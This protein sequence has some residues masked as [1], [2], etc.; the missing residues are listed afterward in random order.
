MV[1]KIYDLII[2]GAGPAGITA[3]IYAARHQLKFTIISMD[4]GGQ[5]A[6]STD[7]ENYTG[8]HFLSGMDLIK[9]FQKH[10][11]DYKIELKLRE[12][13]DC[14]RKKGG[15][16]EIKT[17]K[18][19]YSAKAVIIASGKQPK[20]LNVQ[21][22]DRLYNKGVSYC[23]TCDAPLFRDKDVAVVGGG[24][25]A[26]QAALLLSKYAK[27]VY[28]L[29]INA[30]LIG[31]EVIVK[32]VFKNKKI[33]VITNAKTTGIF[34]ENGVSALKFIQN[35]NESTINLQGVFIEVGLIIECDFAPLVDKNKWK[36]IKIK[37]S[38][39]STEENMTNIPGIFAAGDCTD[40][41]AKQII[42]AAGEG[43]KA[44]LAAIDYIE[45]NSETS[46]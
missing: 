18:S 40:I 32:K 30:K 46:E 17:N 38:T 12:R 24:N 3:A 35:G 33:K 5:T 13:V 27:T 7:V 8:Y 26:L 39:K 31:E 15:I 20:K 29:T 23:A 36:E 2:V 41:P 44:A 28:L 42:V 11:E 43:A 6:M 22:E 34:G 45:K 4:I 37:R 14:I 25:S 19:R 16:F 9:K 10:M 1:S 21:G